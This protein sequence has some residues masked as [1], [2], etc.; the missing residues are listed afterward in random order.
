MGS[1][2][3][4]SG[5]WGSFIQ[6]VFV[7]LT[8]FLFTQLWARKEVNQHIREALFDVKSEIL[9]NGVLVSDVMQ[10]LKR[11]QSF[12]IEPGY[13][14]AEGLQTQSLQRN[15]VV[16]SQ[17]KEQY[18]ENLVTY[19]F[20]V[21]ELKKLGKE[22]LAEIDFEN[23]RVKDSEA[24][25]DTLIARRDSFI[26]NEDKLEKHYPSLLKDTINA[27]EASSRNINKM[28][29][30]VIKMQ[31]AV[32]ES[33]ISQLNFASSEQDLALA[34]IAAINADLNVR[35]DRLYG[36]M[37]FLLVAFLVSGFLPSAIQAEKR[38]RDK[39]RAKLNDSVNSKNNC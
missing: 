11:F 39:I 30:N 9:H 29:Q 16:I 3:R 22:E 26:V 35:D 13:P 4:G 33:L 25:L 23:Q 24:A 5:V 6:N 38:L 8:V 20:N 31:E 18:S 32:R 34:S 1:V 15:L 10:D 37:T 19:Y 2:E 36:Y 21:D 17:Q 27:V 7:A 12:Q 28:K 14:F